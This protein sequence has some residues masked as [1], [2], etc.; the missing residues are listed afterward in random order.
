MTGALRSNSA[1]G[2]KIRGVMAA[3]DAPDTALAEGPEQVLRRIMRADSREWRR[4]VRCSQ[5]CA[6]CGAPL[7]EHRE[8]G[9]TCSPECAKAWEAG[10]GVRSPRK[11][12]A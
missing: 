7:P 10:T 1:A 8:R 11:A 2:M 9:K 4:R 5:G 3:A 12:N 6:V